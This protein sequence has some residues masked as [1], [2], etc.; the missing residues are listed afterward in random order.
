MS[1]TRKR[2]SMSPRKR[3]KHLN[4]SLLLR[5][6]QISAL[7]QSVAATTLFVFLTEVRT[8]NNREIRFP[9]CTP[10]NGRPGPYVLQGIVRGGSCLQPV[11]RPSFPL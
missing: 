8:L 2:C 4:P 5:L 1:S 11:Q 3:P 9:S 10:R 6:L 7:W